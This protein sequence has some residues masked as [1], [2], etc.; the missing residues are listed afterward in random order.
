VRKPTPARRRRNTSGE[1]AFAG[2]K[3]ALVMTIAMASLAIAIA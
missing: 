3:A 1:T 2:I